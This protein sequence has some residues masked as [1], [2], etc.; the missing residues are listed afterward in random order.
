MTRWKRV[1]VGS[2]GDLQWRWSRRPLLHSAATGVLSSTNRDTASGK[3]PE[4]HRLGA[5]QLRCHVCKMCIYM[6]AQVMAK[7]I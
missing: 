6:K 3:T 1:T 4:R 2:G 5:L 7:S